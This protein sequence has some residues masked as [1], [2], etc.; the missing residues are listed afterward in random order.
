MRNFPIITSWNVHLKSVLSVTFS[1]RI[2]FIIPI[3]YCVNILFDKLNDFD[4]KKLLWLLFLKIK[5]NNNKLF[6]NFYQIYKLLTKQ[7]L[8]G[9]SNVKEYI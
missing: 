7:E 6:F 8:E 1:A 9:T 3:I 4:K 2:G 5:H